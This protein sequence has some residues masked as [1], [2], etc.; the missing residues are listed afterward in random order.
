[1]NQVIFDALYDE[2]AKIA[3]A[4]RLGTRAVEKLRGLAAGRAAG[5]ELSKGT[6]M[7]MAERMSKSRGDTPMANILRVGQ[8]NPKKTVGEG[9]QR[10]FSKMPATKRRKMVLGAQDLRAEGKKRLAK[11]VAL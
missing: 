5:G 1:M 7:R 3:M 10:A 6:V 9:M 11:T 2:L 8:L 4:G